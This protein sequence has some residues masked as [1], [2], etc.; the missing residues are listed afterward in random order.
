MSQ[1]SMQSRP[2]SSGHQHS[3]GPLPNGLN[4]SDQAPVAGLNPSPWQQTPAPHWGL[5]PPQPGMPGLDLRSIMQEEQ[6]A[7]LRGRARVSGTINP[8]MDS[9]AGSSRHDSAN[10]LLSSLDVPLHFP[11]LAQQSQQQQQLPQQRSSGSYMHNTRDDPVPGKRN[12]A[13]VTTC[14]TDKPRFMHGL[15]ASTQFHEW[16]LLVWGTSATPYMH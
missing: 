14:M 13:Q 9:S 7:A 2:A 12:W 4:S 15:Q 5:Q 3:W 6:Q 11:G 10:T 1:V 8:A 16:L